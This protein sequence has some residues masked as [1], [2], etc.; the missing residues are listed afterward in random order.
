M[1]F[2]YTIFIFDY[3]RAPTTRNHHYG[4][5]KLHCLQHQQRLYGAKCKLSKLAQTV[6]IQ[7]DVQVVPR[8]LFYGKLVNVTKIRN[9][10]SR[11]ES[12]ASQK[13]T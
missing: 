3:K 10:L 4:R 12:G 13:R 9:V 6:Q 5:R 7:T 1:N 11:S 8:K 2:I